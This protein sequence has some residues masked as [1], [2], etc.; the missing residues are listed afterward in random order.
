MK[1]KKRFTGLNPG[2]TREKDWEK[3]LTTRGNKD[4]SV[5]FIEDLQWKKTDIGMRG[6]KA[7][8]EDER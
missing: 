8:Q 3:G 2:N 6:W 7:R 5:H 1:N 4:Q